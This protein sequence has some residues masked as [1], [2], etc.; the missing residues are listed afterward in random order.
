[1][2]GLVLGDESD[3]SPGPVSVSSGNLSITLD[4]MRA[5]LTMTLNFDTH[6]E[7]QVKQTVKII[8]V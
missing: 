6:P 5:T 4:H 8:L 7:R 1:M 3:S 2:L